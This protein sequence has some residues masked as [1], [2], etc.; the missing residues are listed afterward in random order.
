MPIK[1]YNELLFAN[2][3]LAKVVAERDKRIEELEVRAIA[4]YKRE[5]RTENTNF[6]LRR[7]IAR[8]VATVGNY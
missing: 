1:S 4:S 6:A 8:F 5:Q 3:A 7:D 2:A